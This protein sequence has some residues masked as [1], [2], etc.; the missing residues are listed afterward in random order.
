V[1]LVKPRA[2]GSVS[3]IVG[4][5][6]NFGAV[7]AA[8]LFKSESISGAEAFFILGSIV[9]ATAFCVLLLRFREAEAPMAGA[10]TA[11]ALMSAD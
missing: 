3:G 11:P 10:E 4:A 2:I 5:G 6:G 9:A 1:P 7:F 8:M